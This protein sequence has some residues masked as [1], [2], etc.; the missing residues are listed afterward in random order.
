MILAPF[1]DEFFCFKAFL[2]LFLAFLGTS[3]VGM[4]AASTL[5]MASD[6]QKENQVEA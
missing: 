4:G 6:L 3:S 5:A 2:P 1:M